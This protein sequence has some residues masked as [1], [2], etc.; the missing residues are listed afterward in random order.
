MAG[1]SVSRPPRVIH[2]NDLVPAKSA[3]ALSTVSSSG[4]D[5]M[6]VDS[7]SNGSGAAA[8]D[9]FDYD[10]I[11]L[12][13]GSGGLAFGKEAGVLGAKVRTECR[14]YAWARPFVML[15]Y[16]YRCACWIL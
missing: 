6:E 14:S 3:G 9:Q 16:W 7:T 13:G 8:T 10:V 1:Q 12:G 2:E 11:V 5:G 15:L 4:A